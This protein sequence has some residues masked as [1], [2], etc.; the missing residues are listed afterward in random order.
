MGWRSEGDDSLALR[1]F[2]YTNE[3]KVLPSIERQISMFLQVAD[4]PRLF[5][6]KDEVRSI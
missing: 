1:D 2:I 6:V 4:P 3:V 5:D